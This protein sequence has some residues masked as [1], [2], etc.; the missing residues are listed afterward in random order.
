M[1]ELIFQVSFSPRDRFADTPN[2]RCLLTFG[3]GWVCIVKAVPGEL[4]DV[5]QHPWPPPTRCPQRSPVLLEMVHTWPMSP[6]PP[7]PKE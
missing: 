5:G 1:V 4:W 2:R 7:T 6:P 3:S